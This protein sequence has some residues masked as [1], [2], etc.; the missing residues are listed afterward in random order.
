MVDSLFYV[1]ATMTLVAALFVIAS[2]NP[3][4]SAMGMILALVGVA[5]NFFL[6]EAPFL[7]VL[8]ILVYAGAVMVLFLFIIML[9]DV[10]KVA[11]QKVP[12]SA[13]LT[14]IVSL[15]VFG[16]IAVCLVNNHQTLPETGTLSTPNAMPVAENPL[17]YTTGAKSFGYTLFTKYM[18]PLQVAGF[19]LLIS[20]IGV[21]TLSK[22]QKNSSKTTA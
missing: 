2:R 4:N 13:I 22:R 7:G 3:V 21:V 20:M 12:W 1:F 19:L 18:L 9:L 15:V 14:G 8:Q 5:V 6:L 11:Q 16:G 10:D 17:A